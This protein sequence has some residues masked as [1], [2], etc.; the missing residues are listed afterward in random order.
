MG[1]VPSVALG[2]VCSKPAFVLP[3]EQPAAV[4]LSLIFG[5][6]WSCLACQRQR[7]GARDLSGLV[8]FVQLLAAV[9][10]FHCPW[11]PAC[12]SYQLLP[13][14]LLQIPKFYRQGRL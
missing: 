9:S 7:A 12:S 1:C 2:H 8:G 11:H 13:L 4:P 5:S 6:P 10:D 14:P 3:L